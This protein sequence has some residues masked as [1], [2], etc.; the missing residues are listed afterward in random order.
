MEKADI[1]VARWHE[2]AKEALKSGDI[3]PVS[4]RVNGRSM[5]PF[6]RYRRDDVTVRPVTAPLK[7]GDIV[8]F[9]GKR[10][11]GNYV[12]HQIVKIE[13]G[14]VTTFGSNCINTDAPMTEDKILG[15]ASEVRRGS[16]VYQTDD[17]LW[18]AATKTWMRVFPVRKPF[19]LASQYVWRARGWVSRRIKG[20]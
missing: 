17:W 8:L 11:G 20:K 13:N 19:M 2:L 12:L 14:I 4:F 1:T 5:E 6:I 9:E 18:K 16:H 15:V 3:L 10:I 7:E